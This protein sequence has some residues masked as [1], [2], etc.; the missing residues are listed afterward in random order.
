VLHLEKKR[1]S[2]GGEKGKDEDAFFSF[3]GEG[4]AVACPNESRR[5][6]GEERAL[7]SSKKKNHFVSAGHGKIQRGKKEKNPD[8]IPRPGCRPKKLKPAEGEGGEGV[9]HII[10]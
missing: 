9:L 8:A 3:L 7:I 1:K 5:G 4:D 2:L 6:R 10:T